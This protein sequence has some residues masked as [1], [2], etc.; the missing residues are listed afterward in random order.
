M[1]SLLSR[2]VILRI[3][4]P[5]RVLG[6]DAGA[7]AGLPGV[8]LPLAGSSVPSASIRRAIRKFQLLRSLES[9]ASNF[10]AEPLRVLC[11]RFLRNGTLKVPFKP[12]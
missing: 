8:E 6:E 3:R 2:I 5:G 7:T 4:W 12:M 11:A 1:R 10:P 9:P